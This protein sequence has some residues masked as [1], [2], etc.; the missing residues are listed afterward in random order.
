MR[1]EMQLELKKMH[2]ELG[3]T[4]IFVTHD[5]EEAL[6]MSDTVVVMNDGVIQQVG[7]PQQIYDEPQ[8]AFVANFIGESNI[9]SG[10]MI[11]DYKV[12]I[13]GKIIPCDD[14]GFQKNLPVDIVIRPEDIYLVPTDNPKALF[15]GT[16]I[17]S[18]FKGEHYD[19]TVLAD[20]YEFSVTEFNGQPVG[21]ETGL[22]IPPDGIHIMKKSR[23]I[24]EFKTEYWGGIVEIAGFK[25][26]VAPDENLEGK[27]VLASF[28]FGDA[29]IED[30]E[31]EGAIRGNVMSALYKGKYYQV[32]V[33]TD[34]DEDIYVNTPYE[35]N[36]NDR[37]G[38]NIAAD[39]IKLTVIEEEES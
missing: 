23:V 2:K 12:N 1:K 31:K 21:R 27:T 5:Q 18:V 32:V 37:V 25:V 38:I 16:I 11:E 8:N 26:E 24:N 33:K 28:E 15:T 20:G 36:I 30:D 17:S 9:L 35:W 19:M 22:Y 34:D 7:T 29:E 3:I 14:K 13:L 10:E 4:F 39:K 6:T